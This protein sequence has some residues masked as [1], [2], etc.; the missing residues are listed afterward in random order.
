LPANT[1]SVF[2]YSMRF[3]HERVNERFKMVEIS[4]LGLVNC[5]CLPVD[6]SI[7]PLRVQSTIQKF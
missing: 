4:V 5:T 2:A 1:F 6:A 3:L 7:K